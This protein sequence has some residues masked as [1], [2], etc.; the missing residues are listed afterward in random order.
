MNKLIF[1]IAVLWLSTNAYAQNTLEGTVS[2]NN[3]PMP[4]AYIFV[5]EL[6]KATLSD[7]DGKFKINN[8][9]NGKF[10]VEVTFQGYETASKVYAFPMQGA[11]TITM[12][13]SIHEI[14]EVVI[15]GQSYKEVTQNT[16]PVTTLDNRTANSGGEVNLSGALSKLPGVAMFSN[17][18]GLTKPVLHGLTGSRISII[19]NGFAINQQQWQNEHGMLLFNSGVDRVQIIKGPASLLYGEGAFGGS[20]QLVPEK[21]APM[22]QTIGD[23]NAAMFSNTIGMNA[24]FGI[25]GTKERLSYILR[26]GGQ[27]H[28]DY[29]NSGKRA[30]N[31]RFGAYL[32]QGTMNLH[33]YNGISTINYDYTNS[34]SGIIEAQELLI[35]EKESRVEREYEGPH[36]MVQLHNINFKNT[37]FLGKGKLNLNINAQLNN[38]QEIEGME[39]NTVDKGDLEVQSNTFIEQ[40]IFSQQLGNKNEIT[41]GAEAKQQIF[42]NSGKRYLIPDADLATFSGYAISDWNLGSL[43]LQAGLRYDHKKISTN[44]RGN[45]DTLNYFESFDKSFG[46]WNGNAGLNWAISNHLTSRIN[47]GAGSRVPN[48]SE[49]ASNGIHEGTTRYEI[50]DKNLDYEQNVQYDLAFE[51][52]YPSIGFLVNVYYNDINNFI[53]LDGTN[54]MYFGNTKYYFKQTDAYFQGIDLSLDW[55]LSEVIS[56]NHNFSAVVAKADNGNYLPFI[57]AFSTIQS[58]NIKLPLKGKFSKTNFV[59]TA[60][61]YFDQDRIA[62]GEFKTDGYTLL[63]IGF[64]T[65]L[66]MGEKKV[67]WSLAATN[68]FDEEYYN[69]LSFIKDLGVPNMGRNI[70]VAAHI[71]LTF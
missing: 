65:E 45:I 23:V 46:Q 68:L 60:R 24:D 38:R 8:I 21:E 31:T 47:V 32:F 5:P 37:I 14:D 3:E 25:K 43:Q 35:P 12:K 15:L 36:H 29:Y 62:E 17:G 2:D 66:K 54:E 27:T 44:E 26:A 30:P 50:G 19:N 64:N 11:L 16:Y 40:A 10:L 4:N 48:L 70:S 33:R 56:L 61:H 63:D 51:I 49:L 13:P 18:P 55:K 67:R 71:P 53:Y 34:T 57:P 52:N 6:K 41:I 20:V 58:A 28:G 7:I 1:T 39:E 42:K 9:P 59:I 22:G 69:H